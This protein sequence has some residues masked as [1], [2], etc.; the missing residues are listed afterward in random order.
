MLVGTRSVAASEELGRLLAMR[1]VPHR[2]LNAR[3]DAEE[4]A[5]VAEAGGAGCVTVATNMAGRGT[6][7]KLSDRARATGGLHVIASERHDSARVDRQ[8]FGRSARQGDPG[9]H[10]TIV[11]LEDDLMRA[12][13][14]GIGWLAALEAR[15]GRRLGRFGRSAPLRRLAVRI[16]QR[17]AERYYASVRRV[18][19]RM[20]ERVTSML[21]FSGRGE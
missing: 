1:G 15:I 12:H 11:S 14:R 2:V 10:E 3:Q 8:L 19:L 21:A 6:D 7:I 4:A 5:I 18:L 16:A 13:G 9:S 17:R 20:D